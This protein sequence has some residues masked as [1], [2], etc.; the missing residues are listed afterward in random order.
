MN[1]YRSRMPI[2]DIVNKKESLRPSA[3]LSLSFHLHKYNEA[4]QYIYFF[5]MLLLFSLFLLF[6][7]R[8]CIFFLSFESLINTSYRCIALLMSK[9]RSTSAPIS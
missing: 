1:A 2:A 4:K 8:V 6:L 5:F 9:L 7:S 3:V